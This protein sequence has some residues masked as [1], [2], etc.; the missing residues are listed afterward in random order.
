MTARPGCSGCASRFESR[1]GPSESR[2]DQQPVATL[3][4]LHEI[5]Y[6]GDASRPRPERPQEHNPHYDGEA[7][8]VG[9]DLDRLKPKRMSR[10]NRLP[11]ESQPPAADL[12]P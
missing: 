11:F 7:H 12:V 1:E 4:S 3:Q 6:G 8:G 2:R 10:P 9:T 5:G